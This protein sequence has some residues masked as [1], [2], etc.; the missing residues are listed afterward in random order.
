MFRPSSY[1]KSANEFLVYHLAWIFFNI[2]IFSLTILRN[3]AASAL[4][5]HQ[6][7]N[8]SLVISNIKWGILSSQYMWVQ[9]SKLFA[10]KHLIS[11][12]FGLLWPKMKWRTKHKASLDRPVFVTSVDLSEWDYSA[13]SF[14]STTLKSNV[15][16]TPSVQGERKWNL[17][18]NPVQHRNETIKTSVVFQVSQF[19]HL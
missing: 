1:I 15:G 11:C 16:C 8:Y 13:A 6:M 12:L 19:S 3:T 2:L 17:I 7:L 5:M 18:Q 10:G 4:T 9:S 14:R